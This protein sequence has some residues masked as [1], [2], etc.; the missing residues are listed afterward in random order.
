MK[1]VFLPIETNSRELDYK[2]V[3]ASLLAEKGYRV[4]VGLHDFLNDLI[5][6]YPSGVYLGKNIFTTL[7]PTNLNLFERYKNKGWTILYLDEE[8]GI[9]SGDEEDWKEIL[10]KRLVPKTLHS[11]DVI[12]TWGDFQRDFYKAQDH[13]CEILTV[14]SPRFSYGNSLYRSLIEFDSKKIELDNYVLFNMNF[15]FVNNVLGKDYIFKSTNKYRSSERDDFDYKHQYWIHQSNLFTEFLNAIY[16][17]AKESETINIVV[18]PHPAEDKNFYETFFKGLSNVYINDTQSAIQWISKAKCVIHDGCTT[19]VEAHLFGK[20]VLNFSPL[21]ES[22]YDIPI[23]N[24]IGEKVRDFETLKQKINNYIYDESQVNGNYK[25][26]DI[27]R[28]IVNFLDDADSYS[29]AVKLIEEK[30]KLKPE[31]KPYS[32]LF[33]IKAYKKLLKDCFLKY[34]RMLFPEKMK[35]LMQHE[36]K[37]QPYEKSSIDYKIK[38]LSRKLNVSLTLEQFSKYG[39]VVIKNDLE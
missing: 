25:S 3:L 27:A 7:F 38:F 26:K 15:G 13:D 16:S 18:R 4:I 8:G 11:D 32:L 10:S 33:N 20:N 39:F 21:K 31:G 6:V 2:I 5:D 17:F 30:L 35:M 34:P 29:L 1:T 19:G 12:L 22:K 9:F 24:L 37:F 23:P 36:R 14:G 28:V